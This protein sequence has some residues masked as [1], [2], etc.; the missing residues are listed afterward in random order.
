MA[1]HAKSAFTTCAV[2]R[3]HA[4]GLRVVTASIALSLTTRMVQTKH[5]APAVEIQTSAKQRPQI[6]V[7]MNTYL[8]RGLAGVVP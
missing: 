1:P 5:S 4:V 6:L 8:K 7:F 3:A 2:L